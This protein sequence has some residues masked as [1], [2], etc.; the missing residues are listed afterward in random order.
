M[1]HIDQFH[2][3]DIAEVQGHHP[4]NG[5]VLNVRLNIIL[6]YQLSAPVPRANGKINWF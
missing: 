1:L 2:D 6:D 3:D 4:I 5:V